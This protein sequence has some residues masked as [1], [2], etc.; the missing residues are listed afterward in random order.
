M[1]R[2]FDFNHE[3]LLKYPNSDVYLTEN[4]RISQQP[5]FSNSPGTTISYSVGLNKQQ[6]DLKLLIK[7]TNK[8]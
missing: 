7:T 2:V 4:Q 5:L 8:H 1:T 3:I 6:Q